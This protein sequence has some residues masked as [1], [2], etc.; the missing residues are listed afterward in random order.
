[1]KEGKF[2]GDVIGK[3]NEWFEMPTT[4]GQ[5]RYTTMTR[6]Y[7]YENKTLKYIE[8]EGG[9]KNYIGYFDTIDKATEYIESLKGE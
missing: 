7:I 5:Y 4:D 9:Y 3:Y 8:T 2:V 6:E 1:M